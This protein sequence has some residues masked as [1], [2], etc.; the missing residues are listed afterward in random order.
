MADGRRHGPNPTF[1]FG[2]E[3]EKT[4]KLTKYCVQD[5]EFAI[6]PV[7][8]GSFDKFCGVQ[9]AA[10]TWCFAYFVQSQRP[11]QGTSPTHS[12]TYSL[13]YSL[14]D[15]LTHSLTHSLTCTAVRYQIDFH[16]DT[17]SLRLLRTSVL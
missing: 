5:G 8:F 13:T 3:S 2:S 10:F 9:I 4:K 15:S 17:N 7:L 16:Q 11:S 14:T 12:P 1:K 6:F